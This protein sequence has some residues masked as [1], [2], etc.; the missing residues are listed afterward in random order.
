[1]RHLITASIIELTIMGLLVMDMNNHGIVSQ[2]L[3][4]AIKTYINPELTW[5]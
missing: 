2:L 5:S 4:A 3:F 1:M